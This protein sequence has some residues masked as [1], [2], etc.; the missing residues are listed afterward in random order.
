MSSL[1]NSIRGT[2]QGVLGATSHVLWWMSWHTSG[3][4]AART[5]PQRRLA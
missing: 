2:V 1:T 5:A 3:S 4:D